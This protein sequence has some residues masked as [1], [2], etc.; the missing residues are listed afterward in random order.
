MRLLVL[1]DRGGPG[2]AA[3][4]SGAFIRA[5]ACEKRSGLGLDAVHQDDAHARERVVVELAVRAAA[6]GPAR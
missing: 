2:P 3:R 6:P 1:L 4:C 5:Q